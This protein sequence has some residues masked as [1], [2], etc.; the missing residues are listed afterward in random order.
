MVIGVEI[1]FDGATLEQYARVMELVGAPAGGPMP[2]GGL[3]GWVV[4]TENGIRIA[5]VWESKEAFRRFATERL[6]PAAE[7]AGITGEPRATFRNVLDFPRP[8]D[9]GR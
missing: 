7:R 2:D 6:V 3:F 1:E 9:Q 4:A 5:E 8:G